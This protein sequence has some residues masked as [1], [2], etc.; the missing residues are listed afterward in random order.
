MKII[1][2]V[3]YIYTMH[4]FAAFIDN[5]S[6]VGLAWYKLIVMLEWDIIYLYASR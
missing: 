1:L 4:N 3:Y 2:Y 5:K 6:G